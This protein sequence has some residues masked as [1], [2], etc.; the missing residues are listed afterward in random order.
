MISKQQLGQVVVLL[1]IPVVLAFAQESTKQ[2]TELQKLKADN[3]ILKTKLLQCSTRLE[4][5]NLVEEQKQLL[6]EFGNTLGPGEFDWNSK[7]I[8]SSR[9]EKQK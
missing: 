6:Q 8:K 7:S 9:E 4:N 5:D 3:F 2:L 1:S